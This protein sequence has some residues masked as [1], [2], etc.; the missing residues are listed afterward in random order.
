M[1]ILSVALLLIASLASVLMGCSESAAPVVTP[2][3]PSDH[4]VPSLAK[5]D[6]PGA[7]IFRYEGLTGWLFF[8]AENQWLAAIGFTD[9]S[10]WCDGVVAL[11]MVSIKDIY[12][13]NADPDLRRLIFQQKG[14]DV[15]AVVWHGTSWP[16]NVCELFSSLPTAVGTI[17]FSDKN[18]DVTWWLDNKNSNTFGEKAQG[19]LTGP[20]GQV[21]QLNLTWRIVWDGDDGTR[22]HMVTNINLTPTGKK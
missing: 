8:D 21:Y 12:L 3:T 22:V 1:K 17:N 14:R 18:N 7:W 10:T 6:G 2:T 4:P 15:A 13:P 11:S 9:V 16:E 20:D 5:I 19:R